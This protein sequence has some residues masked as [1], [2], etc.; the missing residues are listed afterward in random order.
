M[1]A[2]SRLQLRQRPP[3]DNE[4][5]SDLPAPCSLTRGTAAEVRR[6]MAPGTDG[7][8]VV[9]GLVGGACEAGTP[10]AVGRLEL[11]AWPTA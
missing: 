9:D 6:P 4:I 1:A 8:S 10:K 5:L 2:P 11:E 3:P 7:A